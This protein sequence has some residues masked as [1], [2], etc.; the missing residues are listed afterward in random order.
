MF[1][2]GCT[3]ALL[4]HAHFLGVTHRDRVH[5][6]LKVF[7]V[8]MSHMPISPSLSFMCHPPSLLFFDTTFPSA[9]SSSS[10]TRPQSAG[11]AHFR[12]SAE[13][14]GYLADPTHSTAHET[15]GKGKVQKEK[16][17]LY[18]MLET[19]SYRRKERRNRKG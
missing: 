1:D 6:W 5:A 12:T 13:E 17:D 10:F 19:S 11:Q 3:H 14:F 4:S 18:T 7:A 9:P 15:K 16:L 2:G 8:C